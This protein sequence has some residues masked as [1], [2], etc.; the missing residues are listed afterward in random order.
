MIFNRGTKSE[1]S[2]IANRVDLIENINKYFGI[3]RETI[4]TAIE[5]LDFNGDIY[6]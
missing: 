1:I 4:K 3:P 6:H 5:D 2:D